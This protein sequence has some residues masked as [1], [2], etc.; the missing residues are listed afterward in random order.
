[1]IS[2]PFNIINNAAAG[3]VHLPRPAI[4]MLSASYD[5]GWHVTVDGRA[6]P[7]QTLA[8]AVVGVPVKAGV[9]HVVFT[10]EGFAYY[11]ELAIP[12]GTHPRFFAGTQR[13]A[14]WGE[15]SASLDGVFA[16]GGFIHAQCTDP[17][18]SQRRRIGSFR[19]ASG[20]ASRARIDSAKSSISPRRM[21]RPTLPILKA[22]DPMG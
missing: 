16:E 5:P 12:W 3:T 6:V 21:G 11:P 7:T 1:M 14:C 20:S 9:H 10:Y 19:S 17:A 18:P 4:V 15:T 8:P 2:Q 13:S 22:F